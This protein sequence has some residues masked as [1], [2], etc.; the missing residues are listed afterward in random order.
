MKALCIGNAFVTLILAVTVAFLLLD[1]RLRNDLQSMQAGPAQVIRTHR[2]EIV[3][4]KGHVN[5][6]F[7]YDSK[8]GTTPLLSL[9]NQEGRPAV[10]IIVN[11]LGYGT[12]Y[13]NSKQRE[14]MV[15][16]GYLWGSDCCYAPNE[17]NPLS[18]WGVRLNPASK[19]KAFAVA[20]NPSDTGSLN[21]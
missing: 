14:G 16:V 18:S 5:G 6:V 11:S 20:N 10:G 12:I 3:D 15:S 17:E 13:F 7:G 21:R 4:D 8:L 2:L 9:S 19:G 1:R